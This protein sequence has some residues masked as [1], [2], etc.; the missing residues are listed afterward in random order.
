M[1]VEMDKPE[2]ILN[3]NESNLVEEFEKF[4][5][6]FEY[7]TKALQSRSMPTINLIFATSSSLKKRWV[8][9]LTSIMV[10]LIRRICFLLS[11]LIAQRNDCEINSYKAFYNLTL[12]H[13]DKRLMPTKIQLCAA[14]LDPF[15][16]R[17]VKICA[18]KSCD[19]SRERQ[20]LI[21]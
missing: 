7:A 1:L 19:D 14:L 9:L 20:E 3:R 13:F 15:L 8:D 12:K 11:R 21:W 16:A 2:L 10:M 5:G 18:W 4:L 6:I 17:T